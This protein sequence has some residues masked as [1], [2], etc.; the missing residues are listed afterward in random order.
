[1]SL[2]AMASSN[3]NVALEDSAFRQI[4]LRMSPGG[5]GG[6]RSRHQGGPGRT[7]RP[8]GGSPNN[9]LARG[10]HVIFA[11]ESRAQV[12]GCNGLGDGGTCLLRKVALGLL[13]DIR[14]CKAR[15]GGF[16]DE[17]SERSG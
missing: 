17:P 6:Q 8:Q 4:A 2:V 11:Q 1:M 12:R 13:G 5:G 3:L 16:G 14:A 7:L 15:M 10:V 9:G